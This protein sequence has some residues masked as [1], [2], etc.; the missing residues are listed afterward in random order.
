MAQSPEEEIIYRVV[1]VHMENYFPG[2]SR[3]I[4]S[5]DTLIYN[6]ALL[7]FHCAVAVN[8]NFG[9]D[10]SSAYTSGAKTAMKD[11]FKISR[12]S[13]Y[14]VRGSDEEKWIQIIIDN[15]QKGRPII[16]SGNDDDGE[17]GHA[18]NIDG[19]RESKYFHLN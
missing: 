19:V 11:Y 5:I 16:Y 15:L 13:V 14:W 10:A 1:Q 12:K 8:M 6:N 4:I 18:F 2:G 17:S 3:E 9:P 7:L